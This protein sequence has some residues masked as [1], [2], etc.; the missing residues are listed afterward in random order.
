MILP[1]IPSQGRPGF[2][3]RNLTCRH[4]REYQC[5]R[6]QKPGT[7]KKMKETDIVKNNRLKQ[8]GELGQSVWLD[9]ISRVLISSGRLRGLIREDGLRGMTSNPSIFEKG[10]AEG[11][12]YDAEIR[13]MALK[14]MEA[15]AISGAISVRDVQMAADDFR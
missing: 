6:R 5:R 15:K 12:D 14:G 10:I 13:D 1:A 8:L 11:H 3:R 2:S 9:Y 7:N 4:Q